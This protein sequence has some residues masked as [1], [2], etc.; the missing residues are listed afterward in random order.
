MGRT[1]QALDRARQAVD[2][3]MIFASLLLVA[4]PRLSADLADDDPAVRDWAVPAGVVLFAGACLM[5]LAARWPLVQYTPV[6]VAM[7]VAIVEHAGNGG[8]DAGLT[9]LIIAIAAI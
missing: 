6:G 9:W 1:D 5:K 3:V 2:V 8:A 7:V 4:W